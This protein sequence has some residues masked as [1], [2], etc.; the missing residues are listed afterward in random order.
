M[1]FE[2]LKHFR[3]DFKNFAPVSGKPLSADLTFSNRPVAGFPSLDKK[4]TYNHQ[5]YNLHS[6]AYDYNGFMHQTLVELNDQV[7]QIL[8]TITNEQ[9]L[10][11]MYQYLLTDNRFNFKMKIYD[12]AI[13]ARL[14]ADFAPLPVII[15]DAVKAFNG[16]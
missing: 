4:L 10:G 2:P 3:V 14:G 15:Q 6:T 13:R 9:E 16:Q 1:N 5:N 12:P 11:K 7:F 8:P